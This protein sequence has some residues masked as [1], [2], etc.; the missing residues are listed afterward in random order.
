MSDEAAAMRGGRSLLMGGRGMV[1]LM[2][3]SHG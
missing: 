2:E 3:P 1:K